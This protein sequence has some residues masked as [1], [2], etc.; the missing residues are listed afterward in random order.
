MKLIIISI[1]VAFVSGQVLSVNDCSQWSD[2]NQICVR[3]NLYRDG[4]FASEVTTESD[5]FLHGCR[6]GVVAVGS[7]DAGKALWTAKLQGKTACGLGD[8]SCASFQRHEVMAHVDAEAAKHT[9]RIHLFYNFDGN[10]CEKRSNKAWD[11]SL[12][13]FLNTDAFTIQ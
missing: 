13:P 8:M 4:T 6:G 7:D 10:I 5:S 12:K 9:S 3:A 2:E 11:A 1:L